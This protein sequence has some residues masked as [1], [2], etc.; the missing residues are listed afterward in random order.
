M[1]GVISKYYKMSCVTKEI[2]YNIYVRKG[3]E[4]KEKQSSNFKI[5][6]YN[7][8]LIFFRYYPLLRRIRKEDLNIIRYTGADFSLLFMLPRKKKL[9]WELHTN[10]ILELGKAGF[11]VK[12]FEL[13][14][15]RLILKHARGILATS[16]SIYDVNKKTYHYK[17]RK[18]LLLN[19]FIT[20]DV[21]FYQKKDTII[22]EK[23]ILIM[24]SSF[25]FWHDLTS[26]EKLISTIDIKLVILGNSMLK[27]SN[28][29]ILNYGY[30]SD[31]RELD[32]LISN[33]LLCIDSVGFDSLK[34]EETSSLKLFKY[35]EHG[36]RVVIFKKLPFKDEFLTSKYIFQLGD[37]NELIN[38]LND[39]A[40]LPIED[41]QELKL[42]MHTNYS[43]KKI[44]KSEIEYLYNENYRQN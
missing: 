18:H 10:Y 11:L 36:A 17:C 21:T 39:L 41:Q 28:P 33:A 25:S 22:N 30:V 34:L 8:K 32:S 24:A 16:N 27:S 29:R 35:L 1:N 5:I 31:S 4:I 23:Y 26:L 40:P 14:L 19:S 38:L 42:Y 20:S 13:T 9:F 15:G 12:L 44:I 43:L 7:S 37:I 2:N 6:R 3:K